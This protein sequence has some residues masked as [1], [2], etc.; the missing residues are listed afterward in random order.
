MD[1]GDT[2]QFNR[3]AYSNNDPI[4]MLD[5][6]GQ[7][8]INV[9]FKDQVIRTDSGRA[10]PQALSRGH[11]G[12]IAIRQDGLTRYRE[13]GRYPGGG[14]VDGAV[15]GPTIRDLEYKDG[16][17]TVDSLRNV[18]SDVLDIGAANGSSELQITV[19]TK[20]DDFDAMMS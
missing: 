8:A 4:N 15:R 14:A 9:R 1:T 11:S 12:I 5:L 19:D 3:Y 20:A 10:V 2:H 6:N 18:L 13:Y 16:V 7:D 17:P